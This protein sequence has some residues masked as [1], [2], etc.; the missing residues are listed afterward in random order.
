L[1]YSKSTRYA[2]YAALEMAVATGPVTVA[3][4]AKRYGIPETALAKVMQGLVRGGIARGVRGVGGG[5]VLAR[6]AAE[7]STLE[8]ISVFDPQRKEGHCLLTDQARPCQETLDCRLRRLFDEV[9]EQVRYTF[10]SVSLD[11]LVR[12]LPRRD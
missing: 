4:I 6:P 3:D 9:D 7:I 5:Y 2:L 8:A 10:A 12:G 1:R 11:T